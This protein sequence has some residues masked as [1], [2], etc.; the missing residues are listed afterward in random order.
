MKNRINYTR[1][2][3]RIQ[4]DSTFYG[5]QLCEIVLDSA[6]WAEP[7]GNGEYLIYDPEEMDTLLGFI[8]AFN[9]CDFDAEGLARAI[10]ALLL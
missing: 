10:W 1:N 2:G 8:A 4:I 6:E 9:K 7:V 3:N 5:D